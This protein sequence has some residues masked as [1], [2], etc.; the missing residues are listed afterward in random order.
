MLEALPFPLKKPRK[1]KK[2]QIVKNILPFYDTVE[3][4]TRERAI[5]I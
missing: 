5:E 2:Y 3:I 4:L 1:F